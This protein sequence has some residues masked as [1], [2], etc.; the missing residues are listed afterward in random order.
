MTSH[1]QV[2][3]GGG[4]G[5]GCTP[6]NRIYNQNYEKHRIP[7]T[8]TGGGGG[9][10]VVGDGTPG[11]DRIANGQLSTSNSSS[12]LDYLYQAISLIE[13]KNS[14]NSNNTNNNNNN[15]SNSSVPL[16]SHLNNNNN[17]PFYQQQARQNVN[18]VKDSR[19]VRGKRGLCFFFNFFYSVSCGLSAA[20]AQVGT[21]RHRPIRT[22]PNLLG[23]A[24][25]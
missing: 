21:G 9:G 19:F 20:P 14:A 10:V 4:G 22:G 11:M 25:V 3:V 12:S 1:I 24:L 6:L 17:Q 7:I 16:H 2:G 15:G 23:P 18:D 5:T 13:Q 8:T